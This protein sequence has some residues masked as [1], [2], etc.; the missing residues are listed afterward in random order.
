M[1]EEKELK[2]F[3][4]PP[5]DKQ[6]KKGN[7]FGKG[8]PK[9]GCRAWSY[10]MKEMFDLLENNPAEFEARTGIKVPAKIK[11]KDVQLI[12]LFRQLASAL[13]GN[14]RA[15]EN[16]YRYMDGEAKQRVDV[17]G[18]NVLLGLFQEG[19]R[20]RSEEMEENKKLN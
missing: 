13:R 3:K 2:G 19:A 1:A 10:V 12:V 17:N 9:T 14:L 18:N 11:K 16:F 15:Q 20:L 6:F 5:K 4:H 7:T 8:K